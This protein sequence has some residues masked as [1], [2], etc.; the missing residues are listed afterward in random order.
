MRQAHFRDS[1]PSHLQSTSHP[2]TGLGILLNGGVSGP[3]PSTASALPSSHP[4]YALTP[5]QH[6]CTKDNMTESQI[7]LG[8]LTNVGVTGLAPPTVAVSVH[9]SSNPTY[10]HLTP[11]QQAR[12]NEDL[13]DREKQARALAA[14]GMVAD[15]V[16]LTR[17]AIAI[18]NVLQAP[19]PLGGMAPPTT[20]SNGTDPNGH[21]PMESINWNVDGGDIALEPGGVDDM[22][23]DFVS[24]FDTEYEQSFLWSETPSPP[25]FPSVDP[26]VPPTPNGHQESSQGT[27]STPNPLNAATTSE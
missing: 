23:V 25:S 15:S 2:Q 7:G 18:G 21:P 24:L 20:L 19:P 16:N 14:A 12:L 9:P 27:S 6:T 26:T 13:A 10:A 22:D 3:T 4:T 17:P 8:I 11:E 1:A 5:E